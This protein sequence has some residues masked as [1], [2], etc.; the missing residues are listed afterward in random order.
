MVAE[1]AVVSFYGECLFCFGFVEVVE[2]VI[3]GGAG[4]GVLEGWFGG[5]VGFGHCV[6]MYRVYVVCREDWR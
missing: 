5:G 4:F 3:C 1:A 2:V 6:C